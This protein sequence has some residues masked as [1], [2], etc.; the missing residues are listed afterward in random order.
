MPNYQNGKI[1][2]LRSYQTDDIYIG[3][4]TQK[5]C[6]RKVEHQSKYKNYLQC[7]GN[8]TSSFEIIKY[9]DCYIELLELYSCKNRCELIAR[10]GYYIRK[11]MCINKR[12]AGRTKKQYYAENKKHILDYHKQ[13][14]ETNKQIINDK[15]KQYQ[16]LNKDKLKQR[17]KQYYKNNKEEIK[18]KR[19]IKHTC[20][21][22]GVYSN[23]NKARHERSKRHV[24]YMESQQ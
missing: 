10:E 9:P 7:K 21:C 2:V 15:H 24:Q 4:T 18:E 8:Y 20:P 6:K 12:V 3:S 23:C 5:L 17:S 13:Y 16:E 19:K 22:G 1:Y 11:N 14:Y